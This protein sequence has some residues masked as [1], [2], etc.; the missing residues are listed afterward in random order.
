M[1]MARPHSRPRCGWCEGLGD[2]LLALQA[3]AVL[4]ADRTS[5]ALAEWL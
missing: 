2:S 3:G 1:R 4:T 5:A